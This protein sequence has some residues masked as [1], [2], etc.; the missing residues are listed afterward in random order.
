MARGLGELRLGALVGELE[1]RDHQVSGSAQD[2]FH[3]YRDDDASVPLSLLIRLVGLTFLGYVVISVLIGGFLWNQQHDARF[4]DQ[5]VLAETLA[6]HN[7]T[8]TR[9]LNAEQR[10]TDRKVQA[11]VADLCVDAELRDTVITNQSRAIA[12]LLKQVPNQS[13]GVVALI[14]ASEDA[15]RTLEPNDEQ[16]CPLAPGSP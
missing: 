14:E 7:E 15:I 11:T 12:A 5:Q 3:V 9:R 4:K 1:P 13:P 6:E 8:L 10:G 2:P 16:D